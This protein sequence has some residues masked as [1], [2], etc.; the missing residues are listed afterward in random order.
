MPHSVFAI[1]TPWRHVDD[2]LAAEIVEFWRR[3]RALPRGADPRDRARQVCVL[4]RLDGAI[5]GLS[6][7]YTDDYRPLA[8][9]F[10]FYRMFLDPDLRSTRLVAYEHAGRHAFAAIHLV[11]ESYRVLAAWSKSHPDEQVAG[12]AAV[13]ESPEIGSRGIDF[14][15]LVLIGYD[16]KGQQMRVAWFPHARVERRLPP[17]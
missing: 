17:A 14:G 12:M 4:A 11:E 8:R 1:E 16:A 15:N 9:R 2:A 3:H 7:A 5:M 10:Y 6:T 13:Y